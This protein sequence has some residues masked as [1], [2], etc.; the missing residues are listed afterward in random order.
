MRPARPPNHRSPARRGPLRLLGGVLFVFESALAISTAYLLGLLVAA[1]RA[2]GRAGPAEPEQDRGLPLTILIPAHDE[3]EGIAATLTALARCDYPEGLRRTI[4]IAD[5]CGDR[6]AQ[7]AIAAGAEV[8]ERRDPDRRGKGHALIWAFGRLDAEVPEGRG[9]VVL[10]ADCI[11]SPNLLRAVDERLR[12][13]AHALQAD[14]VVG[15]PEASHASALRFG[16]FALM[17]TVRFQGKQQL[18]LSCGLV[19][20]GM[21]FSRDLLRRR[22]WTTTGLTEDD[23]YHMRLV[24]AGER[25]E[26][27]AEAS[28][29]SAMP[30]SLRGSSEQQARW[31]GGKLQLIRRWTPRLLLAGLARRDPVRLHAGLECLVPAQSLIAA[32]SAASA[33]A[34]VLL[35]HRRL[36]ALSLAT[37]AA[38]LTFVLAGLRLVR[39]PAHVYRALLT[40]PALI[41][42]KLAIY[43]RLLGGRGP[44]SWQRTRREAPR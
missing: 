32:G 11:P 19:G 5:N 30:T 17:N 8:W 37:L 27:A 41:A 15:N 10:D 29:S 33:G 23:E 21:A 2:P 14:Y 13:G 31:E 38:Q 9:V 42:G 43:G 3:E 44:T 12:G 22:P 35:G 36:L 39:A 4:V 16:A 6:T 1:R 28:V 25:A 40:A 18:G 24:L 34:A 7:R 20:T 26:F